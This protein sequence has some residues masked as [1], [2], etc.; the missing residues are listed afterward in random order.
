M[1]WHSSS[2][3]F[4]FFTLLFLLGS[5]FECMPIMKNKYLLIDLTPLP[6]KNSFSYPNSAYTSMASL[7]YSNYFGSIDLDDIQ[8]TRF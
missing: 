8:I 7:N 1:L 4:Y 3:H 2:A 5:G 6:R